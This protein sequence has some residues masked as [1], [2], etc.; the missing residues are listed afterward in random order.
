MGGAGA[1]PGAPSYKCVGAVESISWRVVDRRVQAQKEIMRDLIQ[2]GTSQ[3]KVRFEDLRSELDSVAGRLAHYLEHYPAKTRSSA[4]GILGPVRKAVNLALKPLMT[5]GQVAGRVA[6][7]HEMA[8]GGRPLT[9][10]VTT[11]LEDGVSGLFVLVGKCPMHLRKPVT[12]RLLDH[13]YLLR[14]KVGLKFWSDFSKWLEMKYGTLE[15]LNSAC[16]S[17]FAGWDSVRKKGNPQL[18]ADF[19]EFIQA[20]RAEGTSVVD[21]D[22]PESTVIGG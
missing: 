6:R 4:H 15:K 9:A 5:E 22:D 17:T 1:S 3:G 14:R 7:M 2:V 18:E 13:V 11:A 16:R 8:Q 19:K 20:R 12:D 21:E 10:E